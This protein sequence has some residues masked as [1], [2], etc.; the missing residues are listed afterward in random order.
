MKNKIKSY[1]FKLLSKRDYFSS[2]LKQK[3]L[4][5]GFNEKD[6]E[7]VIS[8][9]K[10]EGYINDEQ[11][12]KRLKERYLQKGKSPAYIR[13]KLFSKKGKGDL[14]I[15]FEEELEAALYT[16]R[17]KY[18]K[19]KDYKEIVKFLSYRGFSYSVIEEAIRRYLEEEEW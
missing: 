1:A 6:V 13:K 4:S 2:E 10:E 11:L 7:E 18:K 17:F 19:S 12:E 9:L 14:N 16:L 15:T 5:K 3:L 8:N